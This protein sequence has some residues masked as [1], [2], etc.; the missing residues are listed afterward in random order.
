[1]TFAVRPGS[2]ISCETVRT[3]VE[4]LSWGTP[5]EGALVEVEPMH[6][7]LASA[8]LVLSSVD[9]EESVLD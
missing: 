8:E 1:M 3:L 2:H 5:A 7:S 6:D 9:V 4:A